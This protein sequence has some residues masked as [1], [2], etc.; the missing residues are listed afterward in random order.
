[1]SKNAKLEVNLGIVSG[2]LSQERSVGDRLGIVPTV[3]PVEDYS[4]A[5]DTCGHVVDLAGE[6]D[7]SG[8]ESHVL[9]LG[10]SDEGGQLGDGCVEGGG[11]GLLGIVADGELVPKVGLELGN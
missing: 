5:L 1:L 9:L 8:S 2:K 11:F 10:L 7:D 6:D 4:G 3:S